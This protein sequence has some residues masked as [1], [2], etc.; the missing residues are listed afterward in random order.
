L[1]VG[2]GNAQASGERRTGKKTWLPYAR[3]HKVRTMPGLKLHSR[4]PHF[5]SHTNKQTHIQTH[6]HTHTHT[7]SNITSRFAHSSSKENSFACLKLP[8]KN[9]QQRENSLLFYRKLLKLFS[10]KPAAH[11]M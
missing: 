9:T 4:N 5:L 1:R 10:T 2:Q 8:T 11:V 3:I 7:N 6:T